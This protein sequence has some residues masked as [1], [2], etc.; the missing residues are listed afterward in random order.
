MARQPADGEVITIA[1]DLV[2][3]NPYQTRVHIEQQ[4]LQ[5]LAD[6]IKVSGVLQPIVVRPSKEGRYLL[7]V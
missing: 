3:P 1:L 7:I 5:E 6:S 4:E 2:D